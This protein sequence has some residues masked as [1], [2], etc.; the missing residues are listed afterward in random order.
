[1]RVTRYCREVKGERYL[2]IDIDILNVFKSLKLY[3][4][5]LPTMSWPTYNMVY[6]VMTD[7][8]M[9]YNIMTDNIMTYIKHDI[10]WYDLR[11]T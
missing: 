4:Q 7:N 1:M 2:P 8:I 10:H 11:I 6:N 9:T 3:K 5:G